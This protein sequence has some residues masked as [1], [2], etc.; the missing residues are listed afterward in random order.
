[1]LSENKPKIQ[2]TMPKYNFGKSKSHCIM[3]CPDNLLLKKKS[4]NM[5][6][7]TKKININDD[8]QIEEIVI[9]LTIAKG[10][11]GHFINTKGEDSYYHIYFNDD[12]EETKQNYLT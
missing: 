7:K 10:E 11:I 6:K 4:S 3:V 5:V 2:Y 9:E 8:L 12:K 1:M